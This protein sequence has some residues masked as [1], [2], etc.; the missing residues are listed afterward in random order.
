VIMSDGGT[1]GLGVMLGKGAE[2]RAL[3][4]AWKISAPDQDAKERLEKLAARSGLEEVRRLKGT[5]DPAAY[6]ETFAEVTVSLPKYKT[7][8][9]GWQAVVFDPANGHLFLWSLLQAAHPDVTEAEVL[10]ATADAPEEVAAALAQVLPDFF[11]V[12]LAKVLPNLSPADA[13]KVVEAMATLRARL[14][15]TPTSSTSSAAPT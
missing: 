9:E 2:F 13:A 1:P 12:L 3:G 10:A 4:R 7:W 8:R 14:A 6:K 15:P 11:Q 5:L